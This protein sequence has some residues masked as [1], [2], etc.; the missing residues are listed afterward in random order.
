MPVTPVDY[1]IQVC[2]VMR[3]SMTAWRTLA[4]TEAYASTSWPDTSVSVQQATTVDTVNKQVS[5]RCNDDYDESNSHRVM[6]SNKSLTTLGLL[7]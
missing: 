1:M 3:I 4:T 5:R 7:L 6:R 2:D